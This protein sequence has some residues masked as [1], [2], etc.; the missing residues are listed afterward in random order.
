MHLHL[1]LHL[2]LSLDR[3]NLI[4]RVKRFLHLIYSINQSDFLP[5]P[6]LFLLT[7]G[8]VCDVEAH[9]MTRMPESLL[10]AKAA[11]G[12]G[13]LVTSLAFPYKGRITSRSSTLSHPY[14]L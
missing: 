7:Q 3:T 6:F 8:V 10:E 5:P 1:H 2:G 9:E 13:K 14:V 4:R 12:G 11:L